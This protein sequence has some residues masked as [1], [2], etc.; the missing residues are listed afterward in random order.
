MCGQYRY[1][2]EERN[3]PVHDPGSVAKYLYYGD[4]TRTQNNAGNVVVAGWRSLEIRVMSMALQS[5]AELCICD[6]ATWTLPVR[7]RI[8]GLSHIS[9]I[10]TSLDYFSFGYGYP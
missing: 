6:T 4:P 3:T 7:G 5:R 2:D 10:W 1:V 8:S 9:A